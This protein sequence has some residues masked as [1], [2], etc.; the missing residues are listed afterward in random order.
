MAT[1]D[2]IVRYSQITSCVVS[3]CALVTA[4]IAARLAWK[5]LV[6]NHDWNRRRSAADL[7]GRWNEHTLQHRKVIEA[8][9]PGIIDYTQDARARPIIAPLEASEVYRANPSQQLWNIRF[10]IIELLNFFEEIAS[11]VQHHVADEQIIK[12]SISIPM[13]RYYEALLPYVRV[14]THEESNSNPWTPLSQQLETW[15]PDIQR[16]HPSSISP[17]TRGPTAG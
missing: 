8:W 10:A 14:V 3:T 6:A 5:A 17:P 7:L 9:K 1:L 13:K 16:V 11:S 2:D 12:G 15:Y 4:A